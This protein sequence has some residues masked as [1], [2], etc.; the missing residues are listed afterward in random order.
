MKRVQLLLLALS[1]I[2]FGLLYSSLI[3]VPVLS[4]ILILASPPVILIYWFWVGRKF[5]Q[6]IKDP[7]AAI[8]AG[9]VFGLI[10]LLLYF[11][12]FIL[13][14]SSGRILWLAGFSQAF[15]SP[16]SFITIQIAPLFEPLSDTVTQVSGNVVQFAGLILMIIIFSIGYFTG[17]GKQKGFK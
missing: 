5:S 9:N 14:S 7:V 2:L 16:L 6:S 17:R 3:L 13:L 1:P 8:L 11:W 15:S 4:T 12:Q 10:S